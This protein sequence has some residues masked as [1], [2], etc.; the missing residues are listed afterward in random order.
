MHEA[1]MDHYVPSEFG[2]DLTLF[3]AM[4]GGDKFEIGDDYGWKDVVNG[5]VRVIDVPGNHISLFHK[6]NID[7]VATA[8]RES[9]GEV[10]QASKV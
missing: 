3:R 1:A 6:K 5:E 9:I 10:S 4:V 8:L 7:G 2:G